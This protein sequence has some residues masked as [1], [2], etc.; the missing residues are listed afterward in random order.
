MKDCIRL[1]KYGIY[2]RESNIFEMLS[3]I[4][5]KSYVYIG[6]FLLS[7]ENLSIKILYPF[8]PRI[9][10]SDLMFRCSQMGHRSLIS[11]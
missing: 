1:Y 8:P 11:P 6:T 2:S 4:N 7:L 5:H 9:A 3:E 10:G